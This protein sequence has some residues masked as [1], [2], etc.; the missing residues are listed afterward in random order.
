MNDSCVFRHNLR[1][2][3]SLCNAAFSARRDMTARFVDNDA[4][5]ALSS[6][7]ATL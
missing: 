6:A 2:R 7:R 3:G 1:F 5:H 4:R